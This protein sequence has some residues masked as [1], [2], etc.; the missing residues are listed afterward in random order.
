MAAAQPG[1]P[2][3]ERRFPVR[4]CVACRTE[5][6]KREFVRI[7]RA[8][9][10]EV[11]L[12]LSGRAKGRGAYLCA[13]GSCWTVAIKKKSLERALSAQLPPELRDQLVAGPTTNS[14]TVGGGTHGPQ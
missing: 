14:T 10:G 11:S 7:V 3:P 6:Q 2:L 1:Q 12:D 4:T 5:R 8:P 13:D 9:D